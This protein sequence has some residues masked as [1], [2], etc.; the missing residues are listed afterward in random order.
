MTSRIE[1][2]ST[3]PSIHNHETD[4]LKH[5]DGVLT[6]E[7][8]KKHEKYIQL[9]QRKAGQKVEPKMLDLSTTMSN[10]VKH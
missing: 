1:S 2:D 10:I 8:K 9:K 5:D 6:E 7:D 3:V 4:G